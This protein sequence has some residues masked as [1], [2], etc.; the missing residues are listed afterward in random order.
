MAGGLSAGRVGLFENPVGDRFLPQIGKVQTERAHPE[1]TVTRRIIG[2]ALDEHLR[3]RFGED[4]EPA[5]P[6]GAAPR[7]QPAQRR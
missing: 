7:Q 6:V 5:H 3:A 2:G 4:I 1:I